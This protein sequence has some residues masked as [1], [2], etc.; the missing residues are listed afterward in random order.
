VGGVV[1]RLGREDDEFAVAIGAGDFR[2]IEA[3]DGVE[4]GA[5]DGDSAVDGEAEPLARLAVG[6]GAHREVDPLR[7]P[8]AVEIDGGGVDQRAR[9]A[10]RATTPATM[11]RLAPRRR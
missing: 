10:A 9:C 1:A 5:F 8:V 3:G 2:Q 11:S 7:R 6:S 4:R